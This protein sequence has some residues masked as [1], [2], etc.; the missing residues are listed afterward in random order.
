MVLKTFKLKAKV[1]LTFMLI[2]FVLTKI[3]FIQKYPDN[4]AINFI[5]RISGNIQGQKLFAF[6]PLKSFHTIAWKPF[7]VQY[8]REKLM[9][10]LY[11]IFRILQIPRK[12]FAEI[13]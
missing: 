2:N 12:L 13:Q 6:T 5:Y 4:D 11:E 9:Q 3:Q 8:T 1:F 10:K 7:K